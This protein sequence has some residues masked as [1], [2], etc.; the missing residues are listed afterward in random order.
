MCQRLRTLVDDAVKLQTGF[1]FAELDSLGFGSC[2]ARCRSCVVGC[3]WPRVARA[4]SVN[5]SRRASRLEGAVM[6]CSR[7]KTQ[8]ASRF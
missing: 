1:A 4:R 8:P 6:D 2:N 7:Y 5:K 3:K